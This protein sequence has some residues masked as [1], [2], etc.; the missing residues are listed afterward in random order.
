MKNNFRKQ[1][2]HPS[3]INEHLERIN[4]LNL[5]DLITEKDK[6]K[7][8]D[9][10]PLVITYNWFLPNIIKTIR[11]NWN[12]LQINKNLKAIFKNEP[13]TAFKRNKTI[14]KIIGTHSIENKRVKKNLKALKEGKCTPCTSKAW[15]MLQTSENYNNIQEPTNKQNLE[16]IWQYKLKEKIYHL[17][18][19][20]HNMQP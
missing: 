1:G 13:M 18:Y 12:I 5:I 2:Y 15:N 17:S 10:M 8:S 16:D 9:K 6:R 11:K 4:L 20:L 19:R 3:L 14:Q 7:K